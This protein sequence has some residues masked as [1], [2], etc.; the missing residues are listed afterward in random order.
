VTNHI[1]GLLEKALGRL[2]ISLLA[3]HGVNQ[4]AIPIDGAIEVAPFPFDVH[5][6]FVDILGPPC[7]S[8]ALGTQLIGHERGKA[9]FPLSDGL[10]RE[11]KATFQKHFSQVA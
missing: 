11:H 4:V 5:I 2:H 7:L 9:L 3:E 6:G 8:S 10:T 1:D